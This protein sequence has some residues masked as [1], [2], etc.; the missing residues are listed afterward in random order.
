[1][2]KV[3]PLDGDH[4]AVSLLELSKK[5]RIKFKKQTESLKVCKICLEEE[6]SEMEIGQIG[7]EEERDGL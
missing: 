7:D 1:M 3:A 4:S 5:H 6:I 2:N